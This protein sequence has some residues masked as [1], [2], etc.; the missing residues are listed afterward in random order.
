MGTFR[1]LKAYQIAFKLAM[2]IGGWLVLEYSSTCVAW[3]RG[4]PLDLLR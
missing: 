3:A 4:P 2:E 1:E